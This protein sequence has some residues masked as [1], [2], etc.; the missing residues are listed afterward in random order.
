VLAEHSVRAAHDAV[1][2]LIEAGGHTPR[3]PELL[4]E[5]R[6]GTGQASGPAA[7]LGVDGCLYCDGTGFEL[8]DVDGVTRA[9]PCPS[10]RSSHPAVRAAHRERPPLVEPEPEY[11]DADYAEIGLRNIARIRA[12]VAERARARAQ[13]GDVDRDAVARELG[14]HVVTTPAL[15]PDVE[16]F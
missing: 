10:C 5:L 8:L 3:L 6:R 7:P 15:D 16:P 9:S 4:V 12:E 13:S 14:L 11:T 2:R 1:D